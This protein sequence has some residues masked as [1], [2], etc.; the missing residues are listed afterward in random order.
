[1]NIR[2][3]IRDRMAETADI[4][5]IEDIRIGLGYTAVM[6]D[7]GHVGLAYTPH[8]D[9][10]AGCSVFPN[11]MPP[12]HAD[13]MDLLNLIVSSHKVETAIGLATANALISSQDKPFTTGDVLKIH[14]L[15]AD[16]RVGM[17]GHFAPM[18]A[19]IRNTAA[20]LI[21]FEQ[22][23]QPSGGLLPSTDIEK[24]L[25]DCT[26]AL[27]TATSLINHSFERIIESAPTCREIILLGAS[28]P[29]LPEAF[30]RTPVTCLSGVMV[31]DTDE[32]LR[33][34]SFGGGMRMF[35][36]CIQKVNATVEK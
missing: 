19:A 9:M 5:T 2:E 25:P 14:P 36:K 31:T 21:I 1:M 35:K 10:P 11:F 24:R 12:K 29:M 32:I 15:R 18:V 13:A 7:S 17:V 8:R 22:I 26:V 30:S 28:T 33:I 34:I 6:L 27:I 3:T 20:E 16:D 4:H 23:E